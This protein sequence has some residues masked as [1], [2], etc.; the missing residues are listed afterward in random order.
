MSKQVE[1]RRKSIEERFAHAWNKSAT[2][3]PIPVR[4]YRALLDL[5]EVAQNSEWQLKCNENS[6]TGAHI[7]PCDKCEFEKALEKLAELK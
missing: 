3:I 7:E 4:E 1:D 5:W 2:R 6:L